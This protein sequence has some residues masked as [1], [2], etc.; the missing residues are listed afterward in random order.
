MSIAATPYGLPLFFVLQGMDSG[1]DR[2][3]R[4]AVWPWRSILALE[5]GV[6]DGLPRC[7]RNDNTI[8]WTKKSPSPLRDWGRLLTVR[9][10]F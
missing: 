3:H 7:A 2:R 1:Q 8:F 4:E 6:I 5:E 9:G 10:I